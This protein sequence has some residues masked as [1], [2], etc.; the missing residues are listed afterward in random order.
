MLAGVLQGWAAPAI[1]DAYE[2]ERW[3]ITEQVSHYA[4]NTAMALARARAE[5][6]ANIEEPGPEGDAVRERVRPGGVR[7]E[8]AAVLLRRTEFRLLLRSLADHC[9]M[10]ARRRRPTRCTTSRRPPCP[11]AARRMSGCATDARCTTRWAPPSPCCASIDP[12]RWMPMAGAAAS[13]V[14]RSAVLDVGARR[15]RSP[16]AHKLVLSRP[17][18]HVAWRGNAQPDDPLALID[19]IRGAAMPATSRAS[20]AQP[21]A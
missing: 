13:V 9:A 5:V 3:P 14:C 19:L 21:S 1:L 6:P 15:R 4:M 7:A 20:A 11:A 10:M 2:A 8:R 17:D 16:Y 18:Q 12:C